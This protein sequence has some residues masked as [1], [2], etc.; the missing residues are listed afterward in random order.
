MFNKSLK[1]EQSPSDGIA[2]RI[3]LFKQSDKPK[4]SMCEVNLNQLGALLPPVHS[5]I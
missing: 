2:R 5:S 3:N 1:L 4:E